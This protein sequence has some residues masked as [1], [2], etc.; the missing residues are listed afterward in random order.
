MIPLISLY[1]IEI[2]STTKVLW[3]N[4]CPY[5]NRLI[6]TQNPSWLA[7]VHGK[8]IIYRNLT[9]RKKKVHLMCVVGHEPYDIGI[10]R[11]KCCEFLAFDAVYLQIIQ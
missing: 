6:I 4:I 10:F 1:V 8:D 3:R 11:N 7:A 2:G 9:L 5:P